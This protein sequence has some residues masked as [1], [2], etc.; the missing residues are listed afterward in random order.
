MKKKRRYASRRTQD[1]FV[2]VSTS[3]HERHIEALDR[4]VNS[5]DGIKRGLTKRDIIYQMISRSLKE[6]GEASI[7]QEL[8]Y[9]RDEFRREFRA[10]QK[11]ENVMIE[12]LAYFIRIYLGHAPPV[13]D[14][15]REIV[16]SRSEERFSKFMEGIVKI[17]ENGSSLTTAIKK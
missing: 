1:G 5:P 2:K 17:L 3:L 8:E 9:L 13:T 12:T 4:M 10:V 11:R 7:R 6:E 14:E 16:R 15:N